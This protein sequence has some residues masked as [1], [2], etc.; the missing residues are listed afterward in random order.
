[1]IYFLFPFQTYILNIFGPPITTSP[2]LTGLV[3]ILVFSATK[4]I[5]ALFFSLAFLAASI[6]VATHA[7]QKYLLI[8]A[9][10]MAILFGSIEIDS[11]LY[12]V[13]PPFGLV[14]ILFMPLGSYLLFTGIFLSATFVARDRVLRKEFYKT[15]MSQL[16]LLKTIGVTEMEKEI[17][18]SHKS[19]E[20]R[21]ESFGIKDDQLDKNNLREILH[22]VVDEM[23]TDNVREILHD[24]LTEIYSKA[25]AKPESS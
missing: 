18:K 19:I 6:L 1:M 5:G 13:Y 11:L 16:N 22:D 20:K 4:Q 15:A 21:T 2:V 24:V 8:S 10:G 14:T 9:I 12:A 17:I 25:R 7:I 3:N 23:D